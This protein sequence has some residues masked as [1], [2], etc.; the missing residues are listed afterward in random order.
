MVW[1][2]CISHWDIFLENDIYMYVL[3]IRKGGWGLQ[4]N[5]K[6]ND[7]FYEAYY[8]ISIWMRVSHGLQG[9]RLQNISSCMYIKLVTEE[10]RKYANNADIFALLQA[11]LVN[12]SRPQ[13]FL[14]TRWHDIQS[15]FRFFFFYLHLLLKI[16]SCC[17]RSDACRRLCRSFCVVCCCCRM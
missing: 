14:F 16:F 7:K 15:V 8:C 3:W 4:N 11:A 13:I 10:N 6:R 5:D 12:Q 1:T 9:L 17:Q 2:Q